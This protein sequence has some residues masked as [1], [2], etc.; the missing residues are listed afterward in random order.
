[1]NDDATLLRQYAEKNSESAFTTLVQRHVNLVYGAALRRT[2][3]DTHRAA[4][5]AQQ[6]FITLARDAHKLSRH[7]VLPAWLH[8]STRNAA[9]NLMISEHR[10]KARERAALDLHVPATAAEPNPEWE[11]LRPVLDA[12]I[13]EL[14]EN[15]RA[16]VVLRFL[17]RR[18]FAEI[19]RALN[20]SEDAARMRTERALDRLRA[21]LAKRGITST[22]AALAAIVSS[23]PLVSAPAGL[24][25]T[26]AAESLAAAGAAA[27][28][29][30]TFSSFMS[31]PTVSAAA[32][33]ALVAFG[34][35]AYYGYS[36]TFDAPPPPPLETPQHSAT[37]AT[38]RQENHSLKATVDRLTA[39]MNR[40]KT[41]HA[42]VTAQPAT[43]RPVT[44]ESRSPSGDR[45]QVQKA[46]LN[47]L[48]QIAAARDRFI[49]ENR[50]PPASI[51]E[52]VGDTKY[53]K[54]LN[55][56]QGEV[57]LGL[58]L[59]QAQPL[60]VTTSDG[61]TITYDPVGGKTTTPEP[62]A[63]TPRIQELMNRM[64]PVVNKALEAYGA[65]NNNQ[66]PSNP[67]ALLPYFATPEEGADFVE[68]MEAQKA[69]TT[70]R[71]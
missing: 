51:D 12:A 23:Q 38:L 34:G 37:I 15:D 21:A 22:S 5:V 45:G 68:L 61:M 10:R 25:T 71:R 20:V 54:R 4:D 42:Q 29:F 31:I 55:P 48:R 36:R 58:S 53:I 40:L 32:F 27:G 69:A 28:M 30:A 47:N 26:M 2:N 52:L 17:E 63:P 19:G 44:A 65:A 3:G 59:L 13:D 56:V 57:Y 14:P 43:P 24:A 6:V 49:L 18:A 64:R 7:A 1:M 67:E 39:D 50:R 11:R 8:T 35:G 33:S 9:L 66:R 41:T 62:W 16:T 46:V 60:I 70:E